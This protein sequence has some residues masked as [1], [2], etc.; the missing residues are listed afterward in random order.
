ML[1]RRRFRYAKSY[2]ISAYSL[3][4]R[5]GLIWQLSKQD[6]CETLIDNFRYEECYRVL[7]G[8]SKPLE[9]NGNFRDLL[10]GQIGHI[11][12]RNQSHGLMVLDVDL[13]KYVDDPRR[14]QNEKYII[15]EESNINNQSEAETLLGTPLKSRPSLR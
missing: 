9:L 4:S 13:E 5:P 15:P 7:C 12:R 3:C 11:N 1:Q 6:V 14:H 2:C 8:S 10:L